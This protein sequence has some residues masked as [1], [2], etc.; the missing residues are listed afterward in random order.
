M[1][2]CFSFSTDGLPVARRLG[3]ADTG[4]SEQHGEEA[5]SVERNSRHTDD[6]HGKAAERR[7]QHARHIELRRVERDGVGE[8]LDA[9]QSCGTSA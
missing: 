9:A 4:E 2:P 1:K 7:A 5:E 3:V 6:C 8:I